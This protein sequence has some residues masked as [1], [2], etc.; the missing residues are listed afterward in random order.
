MSDA[1]DPPTAAPVEARAVE[2]AAPGDAVA[3]GA[4]DRL[5]VVGI[6]ASAGGLEAIQRFVEAM[7]VDSGMAFVVVQHLAPT[8]ES[9]LAEILSR[10]TS[11]PVVQ[12]AEGMRPEANHVHIIPPNRNLALS[13]KGF[14]L[15]EPPAD[16]SIRLSIDYFFRSLAQDRKERA[17]AVVLSG[18]GADGS[19]GIKA[20]K[21][22]GG[23]VLV[24]APAS[25]RHGSM[26]QS[27]IDTSLADFVL[28]PDEMPKRLLAY[29]KHPFIQAS[30]ESLSARSEQAEWL[31]QVLA[32]LQE[33]CGQ[34]F[35]LYK[36]K[37]IVRRVE[38]RIALHQIAGPDEY[39]QY[40]RGNQ[41]ELRTLF[42]EML[43]G[44]TSFFR[45]P[46]AFAVL[47]HQLL[48]GLF[49]GRSPDDPIRV[50]V[51]GCSTGEE[52]YSMAI[53]LNELRARL[54]PGVKLQI[55]ATDLDPQAIQRARTGRYP[56]SIAADVGPARLQRF[57]VREGESYV[58]G[59]HVRAGVLFAVQSVT[60]DPPFSRVDV[61]TCRNLL[62]YLDPL[63]QRRVLTTLHYALKPGGLLFL[64][65][66][67]SPDE[68]RQLFRPLDR[69]SRL[70]QRVGEASVPLLRGAAVR[71][72]ARGE[73]RAGAIGAERSL[74]D[75]VEQRLL[76][77]SPPSIVV[78]SGGEILY[79][80][81]RIGDYLEIPPGSGVAS[82]AFR[83]AREGLRI[84]LASL[85]QRAATK[86]E[87]VV[88]DD[89]RVEIAGREATLRLVA[90]PG[91]LPDTV[92]VLFHEIQGRVA[93]P[94]PGEAADADARAAGQRLVEQA[95]ELQAMREY[96][97]CT[98][99]ELE[100]TNEELR[101]A[102]EELQSANEEL[103]TSREELQSTNEEL[104]T[105]NT[106]HA[107]E[108]EQ[109]TRMRNDLG[110]A[111]VQ[112]DIGIIF[113]D[114]KLRIRRFNPAAT[115]IINLLPGDVDR[116][117]SDMVAKIKYGR[118]VD[119]AQLVFD[120]LTTRE[121]EVEANDGRW[122][123]MHLRPYRTVDDLIDGVTLTFY[124]ITARRRAE[125]VLHAAHRALG[126][127]QE[128]CARL[129]TAETFAGLLQAAIDGA[130]QLCG[131]EMGFL[132]LLD[133]DAR[134][135][136]I[137]SHR[138][139][140]R[141]L[142]ERLAVVPYGDG[143]PRGERLV[144]DDLGDGH[145]AQR[146][147]EL[148]ELRAAG[149]RASCSSSLLARDGSARGV[150]SVLWGAPHRPAETTL[151]LFTLLVRVVGS[152]IE[153]RQR[154]DASGAPPDGEEQRT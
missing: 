97:Q 151:A 58:V 68:L 66:S 28:P 122:Y 78:H 136:R 133:A 57:F 73:G 87:R 104:G 33:Q 16:S 15:V 82:N 45:D 23:L 46:E 138:G 24:Q 88:R 101:S 37:T 117:L 110:N 72:D 76:A 152:L 142:V 141:G 49:A 91:P 81:G 144:L 143:A 65:S 107:S 9:I 29:V 89:L 61:V 40:L 137:V 119:D 98:V 64:G 132:Q 148:V 103:T 93:L 31:P 20:I 90:E 13:R 92:L 36:R 34:D 75:A 112:L 55:F 127:L 77:A 84:P 99:E 118:M 74:R 35:S 80:H 39:L 95:S 105:V 134:T 19:L 70:Y 106:E 6:G 145:L 21:E 115:R 109:L 56:A 53:L 123:A 86:N 111:F 147:P 114:R 140:G 94:A 4:S 128:I 17:V 126:E 2:P 3:G 146:T 26:P 79:V 12:I 62:I 54:A 38:R 22:N 50:W 8:H 43:I 149:V 120:Q 44:V 10:H 121:V 71:L 153:Y 116:P 7:P 67:E 51:V 52:A 32:L 47:E 150:L 125:E 59:E 85:V 14:V 69:K 100:A 41:D 108:I 63:L 42:Q 30:E 113:L 1:D 96:A 139:L 154:H 27:A 83:M 131:A 25:A 48:P 5:F 60:Q 130:V 11:M 135:L 124:D 18:A 129:I 102:N